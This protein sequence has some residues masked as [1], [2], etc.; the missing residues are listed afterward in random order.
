MTI[1]HSHGSIKKN[2]CTTMT[3]V[4]LSIAMII[5]SNV[6]TIMLDQGRLVPSHS[7]QKIN[8][9]IS[10]S[11]ASAD[12]ILN[13]SGGI[14]TGTVAK[15]NTVE[16]TTSLLYNRDFQVNGKNC[17]NVTTPASWT[18]DN[19][20]VNV[21][22]F[23]KKQVILDPGFN[24]K[25]GVDW[26]SLTRTTGT[27]TILQAF[28]PNSTKPQSALT[29]IKAVN[30]SATSPAFNA[31]DYGIWHQTSQILNTGPLAVQEGKLYQPLAHG[32]NNFSGFGTNPN[33]YTDLNVPYGGVNRAG[34]SISLTY[35]N[36]THSLMVNMLPGTTVLGGNPSAAWWYSINI[37]YVADF[38]QIK[39]S[40]AIDP[41][42]SFNASN[43]Y[44]VCARINDAYIDGRLQS[45]GGMMINHTDSLALA[46]SSTALAVYNGTVLNH[47]FITRTYNITKLVG[48]LVG[49]NKFDFG[50][51][52]KNPTHG[53]IPNLIIAR[54]NYV[55]ID[56][57][58]TTKY[59]VAN[60]NFDYM[61]INYGL[62]S[63][64]TSNGPTLAQ[65]FANKA[66]I[67]IFLKSSTLGTYFIRVLPF[68]SMNVITNISQAT[69]T[70][71]SFSLPQQ[72]I[73]L[74][75]SSNLDFY[76][77][78]VFEKN[79]YA[80]V[81]YYFFFD[82]VTFKIN[83]AIP[84]V[85]AAQLQMRVD[86]GSPM[87][88]NSSTTLIN[89]AGWR[90]GM[91]H[92]FTFQTSSL[93]YTSVYLNI[94][95]QFNGHISRTNMAY[96]YYSIAAA[97]SIR[98]NWNVTYNNSWSYGLL[99]A[100]NATG[101]FNISAYSICYLNMPA[102]D[103]KGSKSTNW[104]IYAAYTPKFANYSTYLVRFNSTTNKNQS[105]LINHAIISGNWTITAWQ[106]NYL[107]NCTLNNTMTYEGL[108]AFYKGKSLN[109]SLTLLENGVNGN[110]S[111]NM[112]NSTGSNKTGY[113]VYRITNTQ[114]PT[115]T[116]LLNYA[117]EKYYL[118]FFWNDTGAARGTAKR[119]GSLITSFNVIN[120][121]VASFASKNNIVS[122]GSIANF[123]VNYQTKD[124]KTVS[125]AILNVYDNSSGV[126][127][128]WGTLW[129][130]SYQVTNKS[131]SNGSYVFQL[132]T[133]G[134]TN[135]TKKVVFSLSKPYNQ[136]I[137]LT[138]NLNITTA[139]VIHISV[140][141]GATLINGKYNITVP[142]Y[143]NDTINSHLILN[144]T[145]QSTHASIQN[146]LVV[147][148][149]GTAGKYVTAIEIS[150]GIFN[151]TLNTIGLNATPSKI[152]TTL[153]ISCS[154]KGYNPVNINFTTTI[155][156][157]P[158]T[159]ILNSI[160]PVYEGSSVSLLAS[161][162]TLIS[163]ANPVS[164]NFGALTYY[165][166]N[167]IT[168]KRSGSLS[169]L[170]SGVYMSSVSLSGLTNGTYSVRINSTANN[171]M[172]STS[173]VVNLV[174]MARYVTK[175]TLSLPSPIRILK[176]FVISANL[177]YRG[178]ATPIKNQTLYLTIKYVI[179]GNASGSFEVTGTTDKTGTITYDDFI[180]LGY[181]GY[182]FNVT[183][184]FNGSVTLHPCTASST[185]TILGQIPIA[186]T[187]V[188]HPVN[189]SLRV[190]Y[191]ATYGL[192]INIT[193]PS[194]GVFNR[195]I[196]FIAWYDGNSLAPFLTL[197]IYTDANGLTSYTIPEI[198]DGMKNL[199]VI[200]EYDPSKNSGSSD[201]GYNLTS[202][203]NQTIFQKW[204][205][206]F[207]Y[208]VS[209][210]PPSILRFGQ[211]I[212]FS[213]N[214]TCKNTTISLQNLPVIFVMQYL[215][216]G[217]VKTET[218]TAFITKND[219]ASL[220][221][222][223]ADTFNGHLNV[224][225]MFVGTDQI[226]NASQIFNLTV[227]PKIQVSLNFITPVQSSYLVGSH[228]F[229][230]NVTDSSTGKP[231]PGLTIIFTCMNQVKN[232]TTDANGIAVVSLD[233]NQISSG[234]TIIVTF[235]EKSD[236]AGAT[237]TSQPFNVIDQ[238]TFFVQN[239]LPII[240]LIAG[241]I[242]IAAV[243]VYRG[244]VVPK[245]KRTRAS[246]RQMYQRLSDIENIQYI[247]VLNKGGIPMFSKSL[248]EV[249]IDE[250]LVSGFLSAISSFGAE[251]STKMKKGEGGLEELSYQQFK[252]ILDEGKYVRVALLL[253]RRP[254][255]TLKARL[256][257]F[258]QAFEKEFGENV[259][260]FKGE[261]MQ[262][263]IVTPV[264]ERVFEADLLYPHRVIDTKVKPYTKDLPKKSVTKKVLK[265]ATGNEFDSI[266]Y[267]RELINNLK[268][269]M[270]VEEI[271]SFDSIQKL[272][273]DQVVFAINP[274]T[275]YIID[276]LRPFI[277]AMTP[278]DKYTLFAINE[279]NTDGM[280]IQKYFNKN[281]Y[282]A[283]TDLSTTLMRLK[284]MKVID[285]NNNINSTGAAIVT[286][287]RLIP[288]L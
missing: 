166:Y 164:Y 185:Q 95:S 52:C 46:G 3:L 236:L 244:Y 114:H 112:L 78:V 118:E 36:T 252:I 256:K 39:I 138:C 1:Y 275:N 104:H 29:Y 65:A 156:K 20:T 127:V 9:G 272:K 218:H 210:A 83:Y 186:M 162:S 93:I 230:I 12:P 146:G 59:E 45:S 123:T 15:F 108:P 31:L 144:L 87:V 53:G 94:V 247:L 214:F 201:V 221:Y 165:I 264:I 259:A 276:Q 34:D 283:T 84:S 72:C 222:M 274:R 285:E 195:Q 160:Q 41:S 220:E 211:T 216:G 117:A 149:I 2:S 106:P 110:N 255:D 198:A 197:P 103:A 226:G 262:D 152:N 193:D 74:L 246:L 153:F 168:L 155:K 89:T 243:A 202:V 208:S 172:N 101:K 203:V 170:M 131:L 64:T 40:W 16:N 18:I 250:S 271:N 228:Y 288:D 50:V 224:T 237:I 75:E 121:T 57:N 7:S 5:A 122:A 88:L 241:A 157:I 229:S 6:T 35:E 270:G 48:G 102:F 139:H 174:I 217:S 69:S 239:Y 254:S 13:S 206:N 137:N 145:D 245:R 133:T 90:P 163:Q 233:L 269:S 182:S 284:S 281:K 258:T 55:E 188:Q 280:S 113:N 82:N 67:G 81:S 212:T 51:W 58:T 17:V 209:P 21:T 115:D 105:S 111:I 37:P 187:I 178:N 19:Q 10:A 171:C 85:P 4:A 140:I 257:M 234:V 66:S 116:I 91:D 177:E 176:S 25:A 148:H 79:W 70:H 119:F 47:G 192:R 175:L 99:I 151:F 49:P 77:G 260:N 109:Y 97:N 251:I 100:K 204:Q 267:V 141:S 190:G 167:G 30:Y 107:I 287:L 194:E 134:A 232:A 8:N 242:I 277:K 98:G 158:T 135:G 263:M 125:S 169:L 43:Q 130:G 179:S 253:L 173:N 38:A 238:V 286:L 11:P 191:P 120:A 124:G 219:N 126:P 199:T 240:G 223:I 63:G 266:F 54:F 147:G 56:Y 225:I 42:S 279:N 249:P 28:Y 215:Q 73:S 189:D 183:A 68:N 33:F 273:T 129:N 142:P 282:V 207:T 150:P 22:P 154:A 80:P 86:K 231:L 265:V 44:E 62:S 23:T 136:M 27:G 205:S 278:D 61:C 60:L 200:F 196:T 14:T 227:N 24:Q 32:G 143:V 26:E 71:V 248:A 235:V 180:Q 96:A 181:K 92:N 261:V 268:T 128:R 161:F 184:S 76:F 159:T 213:L 132:H